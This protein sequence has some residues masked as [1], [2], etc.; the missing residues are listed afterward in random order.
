[1]NARVDQSTRHR[2][3]LYG[4]VRRRAAIEYLF[5]IRFA[6]DCARQSGECCEMVRL[7]LALNVRLAGRRR[8]DSSYS[9][10]ISVSA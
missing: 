7:R 4:A 3:A 9:R 6:R 2:R 5:E 10:R 8:F 1:M